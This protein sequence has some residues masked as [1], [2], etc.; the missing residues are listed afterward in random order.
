L[1]ST[2]L[3]SSGAYLTSRAASYERCREI[4]GHHVWEVSVPNSHPAK[5]LE[6]LSEALGPEASFPAERLSTMRQRNVSA[7][8]D[9]AKFDRQFAS[10][11]AP[12][13]AHLLSECL[14]GAGGFLSAVPSKALGLAFEPAE[15]TAELQA[16]LWMDVYPAD[17]FCPCC[18][19]VLDAK[20]AHARS[21]MAAGDVVACHNGARNLVG[22]VASSAGYA[23][24]LEKPELLP[25]RPN[26]PAGSNLRRPADVY[27]PA[28]DHG[29]P[30]ALDLAIVSPQRQG[31]VAQAA[32]TAGAAACAYATHK[33]SHLQTEAEC[34]AQGV[35]F[36]PMVAE[37]SGGWGADGL[38]VLRRLAKASAA[39][40]G[41][42]ES[43]AVGQLL[44]RLCVTIRR[45]KARAVLRRAGHHLEP[46]A[47][48][49]EAALGFLAPGA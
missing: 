49:V 40:T 37:S 9:K 2:A 38:K 17:R 10:G 1:R 16:R 29:A 39:K 44:Q 22:R 14:P 24:T 7:K 23:P 35:A 28:W 8:I 5:A 31:I 41:G 27:L 20:G 25:P 4:D 19:A 18:D 46:T 21:C 42:D 15:F 26:D 43:V 48:A 11:L 30:A 13:R 45:A 47:S 33:R 12:L 3:H 34:A 36:L 6:A 32:V